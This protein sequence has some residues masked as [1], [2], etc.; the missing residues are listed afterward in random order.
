MKAS[1]VYGKDMMCEAHTEKINYWFWKAFP[2]PPNA[3]HFKRTMI[4]GI[5]KAL[6]A[7]LL[8]KLV[9]DFGTVQHYCSTG[10]NDFGTTDLS[11]VNLNNTFMY[12][13]YALSIAFIVFV[14]ELVCKSIRRCM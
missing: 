8:D 7:G 14:L 6:Y 13:A 2:L 9:Q 4:D 12:F 3:T 5:R 10:G 11:I 1:F